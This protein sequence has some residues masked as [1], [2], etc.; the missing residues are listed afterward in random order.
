[1]SQPN[2]IYTYIMGDVG[3]GMVKIGISAVPPERRRRLQTLSPFPL[4]ILLVLV[5]NCEEDLKTK[6]AHD[7][8][9]GEF[10]KLSEEMLAFIEREK[11]SGTRIPRLDDLPL[12][13][14]ISTSSNGANGQLIPSGASGGPPGE[15]TR[16]VFWSFFHLAYGEAINEHISNLQK[17]I[18]RVRLR[19]ARAA[20]ISS[21]SSGIRRVESLWALMDRIERWAAWRQSDSLETWEEIQK[22]VHK[23]KEINPEEMVRCPTKADVGFLFRSLFYQAYLNVKQREKTQKSA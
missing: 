21:A 19:E 8:V 13:S 10:Y 5:G 6:F 20:F 1:M 15:I 22:I 7:H 16:K 2:Q 23:Q 11:G 14:Y 17:R 12:F 3:A 18:R 4:A 9:Y